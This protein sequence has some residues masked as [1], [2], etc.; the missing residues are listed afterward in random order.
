VNWRYVF[1]GLA[2]VLIGALVIIGWHA[3]DLGLMNRTDATR[4]LPA[5]DAKNT[6]SRNRPAGSTTKQSPNHVSPQKA[7]DPPTRAEPSSTPTPAGTSG[8]DEPVLRRDGAASY[9]AEKYQGKKTASGEPFNKDD[10][11]AASPI[12]PMGARAT[13][14][15]QLNG[16]SVEV[17]VNDRGPNVEGRI[18]DLSKRAAEQL[19]MTEQ[20]VIPVHVEAHPSQQPTPELAQKVAQQARSLDHSG[21]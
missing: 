8:E 1:A 11:T 10:L 13:V 7:A 9:Y 19:G 21:H 20:G 3:N 14:V 16:R 6:P 2:G 15:D 12:L 18:I 17:T 5:Q 4:P